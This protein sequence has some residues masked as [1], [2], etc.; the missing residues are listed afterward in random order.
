VYGGIFG[1]LL[2]WFFAFDKMALVA[3]GTRG[4]NELLQAA[5]D[6]GCQSHPSH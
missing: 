2:S 5:L 6:A 4:K 3:E 1:I